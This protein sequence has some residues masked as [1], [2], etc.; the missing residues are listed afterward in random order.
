MIGFIAEA[1]KKKLRPLEGATETEV[2]NTPINW[3]PLSRLLLTLD[4][5]GT[6]INIY[7]AWGSPDKSR[8]ERVSAGN[9]S[10]AFIFYDSLILKKF[11]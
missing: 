4:Y 10:L 1:C 7:L 11:N 9:A 5:R 8:R 3:L 2:Q 6:L